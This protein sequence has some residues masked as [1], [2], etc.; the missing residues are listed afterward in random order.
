[1]LAAEM[2]APKKSTRTK[3]PAKAAPRPAARK[4]SKLTLAGDEASKL[5]RRTLLITTLGACGW[6]LAR[7][8]AALDLASGADV[9]RALKE[10]APEEYD[11]A[12][13][14]GRISPGRRADT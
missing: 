7:T 8:A 9:I 12:R 1:M 2:P 4:Q 14:D 6:N 13:A 11:A 10:L 3:A 5:A